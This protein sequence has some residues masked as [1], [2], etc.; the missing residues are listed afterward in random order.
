MKVLNIVDDL[1]SILY[2][3]FCINC[4]EKTENPYPLCN[5]CGEEI[6]EIRYPY[7]KICGRPLT[8]SGNNICGGCIKDPPPFKMARSGYV[9]TGII[10]E[11]I[12]MW[13]YSQ[14]RGFSKFLNSLAIKAILK[15][16][17]PINLL[18]GVT[19]IPL[20]GT[21]LRKRGFNQTEDLARNISH[22]FKISLYRGLKKK[23]ETREQVFL[24]EKERLKN[25][26][27]AFYISSDIPDSVN[28]L[29]IIDDVYTTGATVKEATKTLLANKKGLNVYVFTLTRGVQ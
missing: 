15:S 22:K 12:H 10:K 23:K 19:Y 20:T 21:S 14:K 7:C 9:Y 1:L 13:K 8:G 2:P 17:I 28:N 4:G 3:S 29:L 6:E 5:K 25:I 18:D 24:S 26:K 27:D 11:V 16:D